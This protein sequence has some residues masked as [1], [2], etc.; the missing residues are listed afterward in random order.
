MSK[1]VKDVIP[2]KFP[3]VVLKMGA[4]LGPSASFGSNAPPVWDVE[5]RGNRDAPNAHGSDAGGNRNEAGKSPQGSGRLPARLS[6]RG[7]CG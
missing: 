7:Q 2:F 4:A 3:A 1:G 5:T 6:L